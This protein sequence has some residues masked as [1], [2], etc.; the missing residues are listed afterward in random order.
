MLVL[1]VNPLSTRTLTHKKVK[2]KQNKNPIKILTD[3]FNTHTHTHKNY[4][5]FFHI[6]TPTHP[7]PKIA[8]WI[9]KLFKT[10]RRGVQCCPFEA[11]W[12]RSMHHRGNAW[13]SKASTLL[14]MQHTRR[15]Q[16]G[17]LWSDRLLKLASTTQLVP[18]W[19]W[20]DLF[21]F[22]WCGFHWGLAFHGWFWHGCHC[23]LWQG[24]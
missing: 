5:K 20:T 3:F 21:L 18:I 13:Q 14:Q 17:I 15:V 23:P 2:Q 6:L 16:K 1:S 12:F 10:I 24:Q 9:E 8:R 22:L 7:F 19:R 11:L 4:P